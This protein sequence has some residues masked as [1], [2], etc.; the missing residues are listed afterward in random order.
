MYLSFRL[1]PAMEH[2]VTVTA[3]S[4]SNSRQEKL[5]AF[6]I[7]KTPSGGVPEPP[8]N[9]Q[10][11]AGPQEGTLLL[12]WIPVTIDSSGFS[13]GAV[14]TGYVVFADGR[15]VKEA[16]GP[17]NDHIILSADDFQGFIPKQLLVRTVT[18]DK[19][20]SSNSDSIK[21][22]QALIQEI[23]DGAGQKRHKGLSCQTT[24]QEY[25]RQVPY[26]IHPS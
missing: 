2:K 23:T 1:A 19:T 6:V 20:E 26:N 14:V 10:V 7:F 5:S 15:R 4:L 16:Q 22:P 3:D 12:T 21:L 17:T 8:L 24:C 18:A 13:N 11:E 9:V 25:R